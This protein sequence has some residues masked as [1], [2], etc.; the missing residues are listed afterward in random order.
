MR[1]TLILSAC[2][3]ACARSY[4]ICKP[5][6][7]SAELPNPFSSLIAISWEKPD[8][9]LTRLLRVCR[10]TPSARRCGH[11]QAERCNALLPNNAAGMGW[12]LHTHR[13]SPPSDNQ[14]NPR[15]RPRLL[16]ICPDGHSPQALHIAFER[17]QVKARK[18]H[19]FRLSALGPYTN[20]TQSCFL[21]T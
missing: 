13:L 1:F 14:L 8:F 12:V 15:R 4:S 19:I 2:F 17:V 11:G 21:T 16:Q 9:S 7:I 20:N 3:S 5:Y 6:H 10:S 18:I